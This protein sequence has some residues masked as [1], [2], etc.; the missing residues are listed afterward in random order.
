MP[1]KGWA[2]INDARLIIQKFV[3]L[4]A[5]DSPGGL[6]NRKVSGQYAHR[7]KPGG[8]CNARIGR[9]VP[10][11]GA[12]LLDV[13]LRAH[14]P[15]DAAK[16]NAHLHRVH[17]YLTFNVHAKRPMPARCWQIFRSRPPPENTN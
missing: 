5:H 11:N 15:P 2:V 10:P 17:L 1:A 14:L 4:P 12:D 13:L 6:V 3:E 9:L 16:L 7:C 8:G